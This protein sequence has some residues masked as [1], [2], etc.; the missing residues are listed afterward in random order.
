MISLEDLKSLS[1][2][3]S[4]TETLSATLNSYVRFQIFEVEVM[5]HLQFYQDFHRSEYLQMR[6]VEFEVDGVRDI[7]INIEHKCDNKYYFGIHNP[8]HQTH[9]DH[10]RSALVRLLDR[11]CR[12][13]VNI[14]THK[15]DWLHSSHKTDLFQATI[16]GAYEELKAYLTADN[17]EKVNYRVL[18]MTLG[19]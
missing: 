7:K 16:C 6:D 5:P 14:V 3:I 15:H 10:V 13:S 12:D 2:K 18:I 9:P 11:A 1:D 17:R 19:L 4:Q 8:H